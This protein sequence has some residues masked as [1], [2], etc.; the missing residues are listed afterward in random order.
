[1]RAGDDVG[2]S[3]LLSPDI[4]SRL[5]LDRSLVAILKDLLETFDDPRSW[6]SAKIN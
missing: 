6:R 1:L 4:G 2:L 5:V 3:F